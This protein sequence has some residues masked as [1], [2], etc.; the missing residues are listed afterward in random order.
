[1]STPIRTDTPPYSEDKIQE[2]RSAFARDGYL[3]IPSA[4]TPEEI[5]ELKAAV[6]R[7]FEDDAFADNRYGKGNFVGVRLF[8][9]SP[10]RSCGDGAIAQ[11]QSG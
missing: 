9:T 6:D 11:S 3:L 5:A 1:M 8:E 2:L 4:L 10:L 7:V